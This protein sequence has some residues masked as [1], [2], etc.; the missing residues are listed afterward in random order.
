LIRPVILSGGAGTRMWP[1]SRPGRPKPLLALTGERSMLQLTAARFQGQQE[2]T[3][4][5]I[6]AHESHAEEISRQLEEAGVTPALMILEPVPRNTAPAIAVAALAANP[7]DLLLVMPSDHAIE[8]PDK[9][10]EAVFAACRSAAEGWLV[11]FGIVPTAPHTGYGY[12]RVGTQLRP[13]VHRVERFEEKPAREMAE[14]FLAT[15]RCYWNAG[16]FLFRAEVMIELLRH[17]APAVLE[18]AEAALAGA[19]SDGPRLRPEEQA[20]ARAPSISIDYAVIERARQVAVAP[21]E[22]GWSDIGS[23]EALYQLKSKDEAGNA[24]AGEVVLHDVRGSLV[25]GDGVTVAALGVEDLVIVATADAVLVAPRHRSEEV[26]G[27]VE[28]LR[29]RGS[30]AVD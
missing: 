8:R 2:A 4:P 22:A 18:A 11:T 9:L 6:V 1:L 21:V 20:F 19:A 26:K 23:W 14:A 5:I 15:G 28:A 7:E 25:M 30:K 13:G 24:V 3:D 17:H 29:T 27:L 10:R 12:I 16:I